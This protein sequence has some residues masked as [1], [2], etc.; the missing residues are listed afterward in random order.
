MST[1]SEQKPIDTESLPSEVGESKKFAMAHKTY[2]TLSS[3]EFIAIHKTL[4]DVQGKLSHPE[5]G[6][7]RYLLE[8]TIKE[9]TSP[10]E[11]GEPL[12]GMPEPSK[13]LSGENR[14]SC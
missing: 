6:F 1:K 12:S 3:Q 5:F 7:V 11:A 9:F 14:D 13:T 10:G 8:M 4:K 2:E